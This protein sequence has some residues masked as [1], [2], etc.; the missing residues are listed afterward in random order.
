MTDTQTTELKKLS[1]DALDEAESVWNKVGDKLMIMAKHAAFA[2]ESIQNRAVDSQIPGYPVVEDGVP[3]VDEFVS[4][5]ADIRDSTGHLMQAISAKT[6]KVSQ[7]QRVYYETSAFLPCVAQIVA[8]NQGAVTEYLGDGLLALFRAKPSRDEAIYAAHRTAKAALEAVTSVVNPL[9][10][11]RYNLPAL[12]MG[13]GMALSKAVV[14]VV[15]LKDFKQPKAFG[16]CVFHATKV[17]S[18][19]NKIIV[20]EAMYHAWPTTNDGTLKF[21]KVP[22]KGGV[23]GY[24]LR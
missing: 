19:W 7:L 22:C 1:E 23:V 20:D 10:K 17:A 9:L 15:G 11:E 13:I 24:E 3:V 8:W 14:T 12:D 2:N 18:G 4:M 6:T 21:E 5:V 16:Q